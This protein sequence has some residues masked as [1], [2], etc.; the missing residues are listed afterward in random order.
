MRACFFEKFGPKEVLKI[1]TLP[2][3]EPHAD[4]VKVQI[5]YAGCN[6]VDYKIRAGYLKEMF[7][8]EFPIV[9][10]RDGAG[11][12][13]ACGDKVKGFKVG[14]EVFGDFLQKKVHF[15][16][17]AEYSIVPESCLAIK[18]KALPFSIAAALPIISLT[19]WQGLEIAHLHKGE[20]V[21]I[22]GGAGGVGSMA[23]QF[24]KYRGATVITTARKSNHD[25]VRSLGADHV[26]DYTEENIEKAV[27]ALYPHGV[28]IVFDSV[29]GKELEE[30]FR[31]V[32]KGGFLLS[33]VD[34]EVATKATPNLKTAALFVV[35]NREILEKVASLVLEKKI[36]PPHITE[37]PFEE[38]IKAHELL[39]GHHV[40]GKIVLKI[41]HG[42]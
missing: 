39:E 24:A 28:D 25:Y 31:Y 3:P 27:L 9:S 10:G 22:A 2:D 1:D 8:W 16:T 21:F 4:E 29:G 20:V 6:P 7:P 12:V 23:I 33:I 18:P 11:R 30:S 17:Y 32:K 38:A 14:D 34:P 5:E 40:R 41:G 35:P 42:T 36:Q 19:A 26:I 15:G 37:L 13:V